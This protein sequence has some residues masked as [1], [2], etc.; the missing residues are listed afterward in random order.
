MHHGVSIVL[1]AQ[2]AAAAV[3]GLV[4]GLLPASWDRLRTLGL[5][6]FGAGMLSFLMRV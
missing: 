6:T 1:S 3:G 2:A 4:Y 5:V